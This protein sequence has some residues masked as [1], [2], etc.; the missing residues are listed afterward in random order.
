MLLVGIACALLA[1]VAQVLLVRAAPLPLRTPLVVFATLYIL[2]TAIGATVLAVPL[3]RDLWTATYPTMDSKWISPGDSWGYWFIV[4]GPL[5]LC[6]AAALW[7]YPRVR[8]TVTSVQ[9]LF[10]KRV[11]ILAASI[12]GTALSAYC[13]LNLGMRGYL[14]VS[15]LNS[16]L[17]GRYKVNISLRTEMFGSLGALHFAA[18]YMGIPAVAIVAFCSA[19]RTGLLRWWLLFALLSFALALL[20]LATLTKSNMLI[21]GIEVVVAAQILGLIRLRG[22]LIAVVGGVA[23]LTVL[24]AL[25]AGSLDV[26]V[27][28]YNIIFREASDVP[29]YLAVFPSQL[30]FVGIDVGLGAFGIGPSVPTNEMVANFMYPHE[31]WVQGA[32]PAAAPVMAYAQAGYPWAFVTM[33]L[34]GLWFALAGQMRRWVGNPVAFSAFIGATTTCYYLSQ[35]DLVGALNTA[36]GFKWWAAALLLL[37]GTQRVLELALRG[38]QLQGDGSVNQHENLVS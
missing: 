27:S 33:L 15:L 18:I 8:R 12:V 5:P 6:G 26:A 25:L 35:A 13:F 2:T 9:R 37:I 22:L 21:Y 3:I 4:W 36:Y 32:A 20:Y 30:P 19:V 16:E 28:G 10:A 38:P 34:M 11:D 7:F 17:I 31:T 23:V 1:L 29:F 14:G 24:S